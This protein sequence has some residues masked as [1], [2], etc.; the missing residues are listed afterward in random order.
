MAVS[1]NDVPLRRNSRLPGKVS[2]FIKK[3]LTYVILIVVAIFMLGPF[4]WLFSTALKSQG[5]NIFAYPPKLIPE[6]FTLKNFVAVM[7]S[8]PF[9]RYL[10]NSTLVSTLTVIFNIL[11]C[12]LAAYPLARMKFR[13]RNV[14]FALIISTMIIPFQLLMIPIYSL[15]L[16]L[17]LQ[18]TYAGMI[19][20]HITTAFGVFIMR[21]GMLTVPYE[22]DESAKMDGAN[23]FQI[24][25]KIIM[26]SVRPS[27]IT[28][29]IFTFVSSWDDFLWPLIIVDDQ[30]M[31]TL[32]L[33]VNML[34]GTFASDWKL[35]AAGSIISII[36]IIIVFLFLQRYF[37]SGLKGAVKG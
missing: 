34:T 22:L 32:P 15:A 21:Q 14:I 31:Y 5:E 19:L 11:F 24:W 20:P 27:M 18:N 33:G 13:G 3:T 35:I 10:F 17:G 29:A 8:F 9:W 6:H 7:D 37:V 12:S 16:H 1:R 2:A 30:D 36:P 23:S 28:L 25:R 4:L 26:P